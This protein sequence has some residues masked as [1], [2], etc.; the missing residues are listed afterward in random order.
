[1]PNYCFSSSQPFQRYDILHKSK[2]FR[3]TVPRN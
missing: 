2:R 1:M 3:G